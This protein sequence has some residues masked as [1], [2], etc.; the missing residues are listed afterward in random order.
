MAQGK[1]QEIDAFLKQFEAQQQ[2]LNEEL[3][4]LGLP[5]LDDP[6]AFNPLEGYH[7]YPGQCRP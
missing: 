7:Q 2:K 5:D 4:A 1:K 6:E 3:K